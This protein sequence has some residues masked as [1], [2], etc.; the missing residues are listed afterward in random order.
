[1]WDSVKVSSGVRQ[2]CPLSPLRAHR[3]T[4]PPGGSKGPG[5]LLRTPERSRSRAQRAPQTLVRALS[6]PRPSLK[7]RG[8]DESQA[9]DAAVPVIATTLLVQRPFGD[10]SEFEGLPQDRH[11]VQ[12]GVYK[13]RAPP[14]AGSTP[15]ASSRRASNLARAARAWVHP[16][17]LCCVA[18][19]ALP[20][21]FAQQPLHQR[22]RRS[23]QRAGAGG[24]PEEDG[25]QVSTLAMRPL[26]NSTLL[27]KIVEVE[28]QIGLLLLLFACS[29]P[30]L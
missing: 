23:A 26:S 21:H 27:C 25:A 16:I 30:R 8:G 4:S 24:R 9:A 5:R 18:D 10:L 20:R 7:R 15:A 22:R 6:T 13:V 1:M 14:D 17:P 29:R 19:P 28:G 3:P 2:G 11:G 12:K